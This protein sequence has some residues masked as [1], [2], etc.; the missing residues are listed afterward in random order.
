MADRHLVRLGLVITLGTLVRRLRGVGDLL[1]QPRTIVTVTQMV[2]E[3]ILVQEEL[4]TNFAI[5]SDLRDLCWQSSP[6]LLPHQRHN[7]S[8][9]QAVMFQQRVSVSANK[10][11]SGTFKSVRWHGQRLEY[12]VSEVVYLMIALQTLGNMSG[13]YMIQT[14]LL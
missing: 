1:G 2:V 9:R 11:T 3:G 4:R 7:N 5:V 14:L 10:R 13:K 6:H 8:V 12:H